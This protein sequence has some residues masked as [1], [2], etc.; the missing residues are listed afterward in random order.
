MTT[1]GKDE[2]WKLFQS[3][4]GDIYP[5]RYNPEY[6]RRLTEM[7]NEASALLGER[8]AL[9]LVHNYQ[10]PELQELAGLSG[11]YIGDS[12]GLVMKARETPYRTIIFCSVHFM[13]ETA[14][15]LL[16]DR[17]ILI[18]AR[19]GCSLADPIGAPDVLRWRSRN[20]GGI[21]VSYINTTA[22]VKAESDFICTSRNAPAV[23][24]HA[25]KSSPGSP[26]LF[27]PDKYLAAH[28]ARSLGM[29]PAEMD[30]WQGACHVHAKLNET[31]IEKAL[32]E[33]P[34][35]ELLIH[36]ECGCTSSCLARTS[37]KD[38]FEAQFLST[39]GMLN[40]ARE[41]SAQKFLVATEAG[42][43][44]RLRREIPGKTFTAVSANAHCEYMKMITLEGL[45]ECLRDADNAIYEVRV[46]KGI[47]DR[48]RGAIERG[49]AIQ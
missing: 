25:R 16:P 22:A 8:R 1:F 9:L 23:V 12:Y 35:A 26:I 40:R 49:M 10:L 15:V 44:W 19:P 6:A 46:P 34:D 28:V 20:P 43:V 31:V 24:A 5:G 18:P 21:V 39:E 2:L 29:H 27:L 32:A 42:I 4:A 3:H 30:T 37:Q 48:A 47:A 14:A 7:A 17:R 41:S 45:L 36:P 33:H 11:G 38:G 13:A